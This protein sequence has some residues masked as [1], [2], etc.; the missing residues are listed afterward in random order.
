MSVAKFSSPKRKRTGPV[1][2]SKR[3]NCQ[4]SLHDP[5]KYFFTSDKTN[6][7]DCNDFVY[8]SDSFKPGDVNSSSSQRNHRNLNCSSVD[9]G[10]VQDDSV[11]ISAISPTSSPPSFIYDSHDNES[12][13]Y[14][15]EEIEEIEDTKITR[16]LFNDANDVDDDVKEKNLSNGWKSPVKHRRPLN[17]SVSV[18]CNSTFFMLTLAP[19]FVF[20]CGFNRKRLQNVFRFGR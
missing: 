11:D 17:R 14:G 9:S 18:L 20:S 10:N 12:C 6:E 7:Y 13:E 16:T 5:T 19:L 2:V 1:D 3:N 15:Y 8:D 4:R